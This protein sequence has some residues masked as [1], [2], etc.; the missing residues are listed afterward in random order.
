MRLNRKEKKRT[1]EDRT[2]PGGG[3]AAEFLQYHSKSQELESIQNICQK[4]PLTHR[5]SNHGNRGGRD[6]VP[7]TGM[8]VAEMF[9]I[10]KRSRSDPSPTAACEGTGTKRC[11]ASG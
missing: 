5:C 10:P 3:K 6:R 8:R 7:T 2:G 1:I 4:L 9:A 11:V